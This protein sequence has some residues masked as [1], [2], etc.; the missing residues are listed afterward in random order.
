MYEK[1]CNE[2]DYSLIILLFH[3]MYSERISAYTAGCETVWAID[4]LLLVIAFCQ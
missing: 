1:F 4:V 2:L 3:A